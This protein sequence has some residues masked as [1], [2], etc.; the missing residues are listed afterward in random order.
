MISICYIAFI[1]EVKTDICSRFP[2]H[3]T[4][5]VPRPIYTY[6]QRLYTLTYYYII[7][8]VLVDKILEKWGTVIG[9]LFGHLKGTYAYKERTGLFIRI[10]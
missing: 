3:S 9:L 5:V 8:D 7:K 6:F 4:G 1:T 10:Y 2:L